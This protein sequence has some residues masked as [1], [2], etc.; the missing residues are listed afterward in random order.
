MLAKV[1]HTSHDGLDWA[2][3]GIATA[4]ES[5]DLATNAI[6]LISECERSKIG[7]SYL[8]CRGGGEVE[9][10]IGSTE[11]LD[12]SKMKGLAIGPGIG[13][14]SRTKQKEEG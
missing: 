9:A 2:K 11:K 1:K 10:L 3:M 12:I 4:P 5:Y 7:G 8:F 14:F 6:L 13:V